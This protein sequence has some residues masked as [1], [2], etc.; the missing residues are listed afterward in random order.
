MML[1]LDALASNYINFPG[2]GTVSQWKFYNQPFGTTNRFGSNLSLN[3]I[4]NTAQVNKVHFIGNKGMELYI[5]FIGGQYDH[6]QGWIFYP[7]HR[8]KELVER[9][10]QLFSPKFGLL[11]IESKDDAE[12]YFET[13]EIFQLLKEELKGEVMLAKDSWKLTK[14]DSSEYYEY[15]LQSTAN[16]NIQ[17]MLQLSGGTPRFIKVI[18]KSPQLELLI[19][20]S[21]EAGTSYTVQIFRAIIYNPETQKFH[22]DFPYMY[23]ANQKKYQKHFPQPV[24]EFQ[25]KRKIRITNESWMG[26]KTIAY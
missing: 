25:E 21:G 22:G 11:N 3:D 26:A 14:T 16:E 20:F 8:P 18:K 19:Y 2:T 13:P 17:A 1:S 24:W 10:A 6:K 5:R 15:Y 7:Y 4:Y 9:K 12:K 23:K